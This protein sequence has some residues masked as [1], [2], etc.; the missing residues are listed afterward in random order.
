MSASPTIGYTSLTVYPNQAEDRHDVLTPMHDRA[1]ET[2]DAKVQ[3]A[4]TADS[5]SPLDPL[6]A[7]KFLEMEGV[8]KKL[9]K[10]IKKQSGDEIDSDDED[11][12]YRAE[13][14]TKWDK[15]IRPA[16]TAVLVGMG[17]YAAHYVKL[18]TKDR[19][20]IP[21]A[22]AGMAKTSLKSMLRVWSPAARLASITALFA[23]AWLASNY[24]DKIGLDLSEYDLEPFFFAAAVMPIAERGIKLFNLN[25]LSKDYPSL[26]KVKFLGIKFG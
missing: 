2:K 23:S 14:I 7:A 24:G 26:K 17:I 19:L 15:I 12:N 3:I 5:S 1:L 4:E 18:H 10:S 25:K 22:I 6:V 16:I 21:M 8:I 20:F 11:L 13:N 9:R